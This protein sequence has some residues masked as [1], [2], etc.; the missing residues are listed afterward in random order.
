MLTSNHINSHPSTLLSPLT[1]LRSTPS[2]S[3][4]TSSSTSRHNALDGAAIIARAKSTL[5]EI[6][7]EWGS[8]RKILNCWDSF[9]KHLHLHINMTSAIECRWSNCFF[10][11]NPE[12]MVRHVDSTHLS[13]IP[14]PCPS[15]ECRESFT[16]DVLLPSH[17]STTHG[18]LSGASQ[19][20]ILMHPSAKLSRPPPTQPVQLNC[21]SLPFFCIS[22][23]P[24]SLPSLSHHPNALDF[25]Q[26]SQVLPSQSRKRQKLD[27][28]ST[29]E[30]K[31]MIA[32]QTQTGEHQGSSEDEDD[33]DCPVEFGD[34]PA[35]VQVESRSFAP[36]GS[37]IFGVSIP[38]AAQSLGRERGDLA[39]PALRR[40]PTLGL[41]GEE[42]RSG[43]QLG[44]EPKTSI[45]WEA[46]L[47]NPLY[48]DDDSVQQL[49]GNTPLAEPKPSSNP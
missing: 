28:K 46:L 17:F 47:A 30:T 13:R 22:A 34:L 29:Q 38:A 35:N 44:K 32:P 39:R 40:G 2:H 41:E 45:G 3:A 9:Q 37:N 43:M 21:K 42:S 10:Q 18:L 1:S 12:E 11:S 16:R 4:S 14:I 5:T 7:C 33:S 26:L 23:P 36:D 27:F 6:K 19:G 15:Q 25:S 31:I 20:N 48:Q 8:C 49:E 24:V